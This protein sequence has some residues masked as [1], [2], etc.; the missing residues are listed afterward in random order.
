MSEY[1][2][3]SVKAG[4]IVTFGMY[5][6]S[7]VTGN[8]KEPIEWKVLDVKDG[9]ALLIS[10]LG[11]DN[12]MY[13][14]DNTTVTWESCGMRKWLN[15]EFADAALTDEEKARLVE[16]HLENK[17][18]LVHGAAGG[19][20]TDDKIFALSIDEV[21]ELMPNEEDRTALGSDYARAKGA[22]CH[23]D[24]GN[25]W[26]WLRSPGYY[27]SDAAGVNYYGYLHVSGDNCSSPSDAVR[28]VMWVT[29]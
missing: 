24:N 23:S 11:L 27:T 1:I 15:G 12:V 10:V 16:V 2:N 28:P 19:N 4:D 20:D 25:C 22:F 29:L 26:W 13:N 18:S 8:T 14:T 21:K 5:P 3:G 17:D 6:Q 9:K 7:D